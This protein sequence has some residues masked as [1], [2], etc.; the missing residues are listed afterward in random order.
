MSPQNEI[1]VFSFLHLVSGSSS[2]GGMGTSCLGEESDLDADDEF[3]MDMSPEREAGQDK[4]LFE[5]GDDFSF[6]SSDNNGFTMEV[7]CT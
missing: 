4:P 6:K 3:G 2:L 1:D 7:N 5:D